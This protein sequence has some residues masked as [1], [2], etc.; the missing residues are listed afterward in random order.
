MA[1]LTQK[2]VILRHLQ[3]FKTITTWEAYQE[4][5]ITRLPSRIHELRKIYNISDETINFTNRYGNPGRYKKYKLE[6]IK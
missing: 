2:Q 3:D 1:N 6:G 5:G 4:Y